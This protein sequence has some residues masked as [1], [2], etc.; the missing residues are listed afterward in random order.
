MR[1]RYIFILIRQI[2][3][4]QLYIHADSDYYMAIIYRLLTPAYHRF[5]YPYHLLSTKL[6]MTIL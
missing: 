6:L 2:A 4:M 5:L 3:G 1:G